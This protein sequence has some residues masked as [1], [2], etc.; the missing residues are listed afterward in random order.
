MKLYTRLLAA[1]LVVAMAVTFMGCHEKNETVLTVGDV[2]IPSGLYLAFQ[3]EGYTELMN[4]VNDQLEAKDEASQITGYADY[5][6]YEYEEKPAVDYIADYALNLA[7][8]YAMVEKK[9]VEFGLELT[10]E[11]T[12]YVKDYAA[13]YWDQSMGPYYEANGVGLDSYRELMTFQMKKS[14][15]FEY[16]Y[17]KPNEETG[18]GGIEQVADKELLKLFG[19]DYIM[20]DSVDFALTDEEGK[21]LTET[22]I[23]TVKGMADK[24]AKQ[25]NAGEKTF[26]EIVK[27]YT[28]NAPSNVVEPTKEDPATLSK[29]AAIYS[30][31]DEDTTMYD[32]FGAIKKEK[33]FEYDK[34]YVVGGK[35]EGAYYLAI[36]YNQ[37]K[38]KFRFEQQRATLLHSL[39][40]ETF[41]ELLAKEAE[42]LNVVKDE[43][44]LKYYNP[45]KIDYDKVTQ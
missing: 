29:T 24:Y 28:G 23:E 39:K 42:A 1:L 14:M 32:M 31:D 12:D 10:K 34:A 30:A 8:E 27:A 36:L 3:L 13:Y 43:G 38:D 9:F 45:S 17:D 26:S 40:S 6:N 44:L 15:L 19:S 25:I 16:Y 5:F 22:Q 33:N 41:D 11:D 7:K 35:D 37:Q 21:E 20:V 4:G 18:K 2:A